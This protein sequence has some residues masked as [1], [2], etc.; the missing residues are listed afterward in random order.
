MNRGILFSIFRKTLLI[1]VFTAADFPLVP[2]CQNAKPLSLASLKTSF[3][4][5]IKV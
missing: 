2:V 5:F 1:P 3:D 4:Y